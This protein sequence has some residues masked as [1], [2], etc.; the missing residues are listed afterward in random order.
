[1]RH[2]FERILT[3]MDA[4][5]VVGR[6]LLRKSNHDFSKKEQ[7]RLVEDAK[8][9]AHV[10]H[11]SLEDA[12]GAADALDLVC[13]TEDKGIPCQ[14]RLSLRQKITG[15][16][17]VF[18]KV[19]KALAPINIRDD[20][21]TMKDVISAKEL[22]LLLVEERYRKPLIELLEKDFP[23]M[24]STATDIAKNAEKILSGLATTIEASVS[25]FKHLY[26]LGRQMV[27]PGKFIDYVEAEH[28]FK[29]LAQELE[30][31]RGTMTHNLAPL[32]PHI[33]IHIETA[34]A[35]LTVLSNWMV[36]AQE[37]VGCAVRGKTGEG[38]GGGEKKRR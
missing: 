6:V 11:E 4:F 3:V 7:L 28:P 29:N 2:A 10:D 24:K 37:V 30:D 9:L 22:P 13:E 12:V 34:A 32:M 18:N 36:A 26:G 1:M 35:Q 15:V 19:R 38:W 31:I 23:Q 14:E 33:S 16:Q 8:K 27:N 20:L 21:K 17:E 25:F 5:T